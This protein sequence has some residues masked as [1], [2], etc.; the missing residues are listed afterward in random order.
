MSS[1]TEA[2]TANW[3]GIGEIAKDLARGVIEDG[4]VV[5]LVGRRARH[6]PREVERPVAERDARHPA[7][8]KRLQGRRES[9][10]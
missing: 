9:A 5:E 7:V 6:G 10:A 1:S 4:L 8:A 3:S 2:L